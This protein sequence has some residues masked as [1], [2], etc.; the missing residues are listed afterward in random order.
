MG[1]DAQLIAAV[2]HL[3]KLIAEKPIPAAVPPAKP[4]KSFENGREIGRSPVQ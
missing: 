3:K 1:Q 2:E 4:D